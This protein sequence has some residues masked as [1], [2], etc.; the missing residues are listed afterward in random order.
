[1]CRTAARLA[2]CIRHRITDKNGTKT[3]DFF[4]D[5]FETKAFD[6][7]E[8]PLYQPTTCSLFCGVKLAFDP[9]AH[10]HYHVRI[11]ITK[12]CYFITDIFTFL[13]YSRYLSVIAFI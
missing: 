13:Y 5:K 3:P 12:C 2:Q 11:Q 4:L 10:M 8:E 7:P 6:D 1:M 9:T